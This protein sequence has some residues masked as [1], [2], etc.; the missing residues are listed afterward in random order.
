MNFINNSQITAEENSLS[1]VDLIEPV[2]SYIPYNSLGD[3]NFEIL[4]YRLF[5]KEIPNEYKGLHVGT[6]LM[7]GVRD[8]GRDVTFVLNGHVDGVVQCKNLKDKFTKPALIKEIIKTALFMKKEGVLSYFN[9]Y[10]IVSPEGCNPKAKSLIQNFSSQIEAEDIENYFNQVRDDFES[11]NEMK[12]SEEKDDLMSLFNRIHVFEVTRNELDSLLEKHPDV[13]RMHFKTT[14]I[15]DCD[16]NRKMIKE[17]L[18]E[19]GMRMLTDED[20]KIMQENIK[21]IPENYRARLLGIDVFGL[22]TTMFGG[23]SDD[24]RDVWQAVVD[25]KLKINQMVSN[26]IK[27]EIRNSIY[28]RITIP[29]VHTKKVHPHSVFFCEP[30]ITQCVLF[31]YTAKLFP[32]FLFETIGHLS[33]RDEVEKQCKQRIVATASQALQGDY[34]SFAGDASLVESKKNIMEY[35][36]QGLNSIKDV[37]LHLESDLKL[38]RP[39][40]DEIIDSLLEKYKYPQTIVMHN[41][42]I[43]DSKQYMENV[44][45][46]L[47]SRRECR[48]EYNCQDMIENMKT[49]VESAVKVMENKLN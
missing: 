34:S 15:I 9:R 29:L 28:S 20:L 45:K 35:A 43:L 22:P 36:L 19:Y 18:D 21:E 38:L 16:Q 40:C 2:V 10:W 26:R 30:Y 41:L 6:Y 49:T 23:H 7:E 25:L 24:E 14:A 5:E 44:A 37:I 39:V 13:K 12:Y 8:Q 27:E 31:A 33:N 1:K 32:S 4:V 3:R 47:K 42:S 46:T 11:F 48:G 17:V